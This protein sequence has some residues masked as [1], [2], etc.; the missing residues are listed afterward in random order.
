M[1]SL[2]RVTLLGN[3]GR[4]PELRYLDSGEAKALV[5]LATT[6][7]WKDKETGEQREAT[8]WHRLNFFRRQAEVVGEYVRKGDQLLVEGK[9]TTKKWTDKNGVE[10]YTTEIQVQSFQLLGGHREEAP[11]TPAP[12]P[13]AQRPAPRQQSAQQELDDS[14]VPF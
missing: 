9:I 10:K 12:K 14:D 1:A 3:V 11:K 8:E 4:D 2:N 5:S 6:E 13:Q 7:K